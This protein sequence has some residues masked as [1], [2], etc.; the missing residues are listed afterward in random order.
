[1]NEEQEPGRFLGEHIKREAK[2]KLLPKEKPAWQ[3]IIDGME[4]VS[5]SPE[6]SARE[7]EIAEMRERVWRQ[8]LWEEASAAGQFDREKLRIALFEITR[9]IEQYNLD[10]VA[11][12]RITRN[13]LSNRSSLPAV[14][15]AAI[16]AVNEYDPDNPNVQMT[17]E[18]LL[19]FCAQ[20]DL[21]AACKIEDK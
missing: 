20:V 11:E 13:W 1:M 9:I 7:T 18:E 14:L 2:K 3:H 6:L 17:Q 12:E 5:D 16:R 19:T 8:R 10:M 21:I 15:V 4:H